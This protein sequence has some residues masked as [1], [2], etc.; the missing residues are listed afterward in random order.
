MILP[1]EILGLVIAEAWALP[2]TP[3]QRLQMAT[4]SLLVSKAFAWEF[5]RVFCTDIHILTPSHLT[6]VLRFVLP[7]FSVA[8]RSTDSPFSPSEICRSIS[9]LLQ[10]NPHRG[11]ELSH[12]L[13]NSILC[14]MPHLSRSLPN[15]QRVSV[16]YHN[17]WFSDPYLAY[18]QLP[19]HVTEL[20]VAFTHSNSFCK[21]RLKKN[22]SLFAD[23]S[24]AFPGVKKLTVVGGNRS[25]V[26]QLVRACHNAKSVTS[27]TYKEPV[28][29]MIT[30]ETVAPR[31]K[32][33]FKMN[34][35]LRTT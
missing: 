17:W 5:N 2:L 13:W 7:R 14:I 1:L 15:V 21:E 29:Q 19:K 31:P 10:V 28:M 3:F 6:H 35:V 4:S 33:Q 26:S 20:D 34:A 23:P 11:N 30:Q 16:N 9:F 18:L 22:V 12:P 24:F 25:F 27:D 8:F 32:K